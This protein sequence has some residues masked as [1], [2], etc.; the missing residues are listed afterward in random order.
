[1]SYMTGGC[2][3]HPDEPVDVSGDTDLIAID[4][5]SHNAGAIAVVI[6]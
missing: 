1:M 4:E 6:H 3:E 5:V 2:N